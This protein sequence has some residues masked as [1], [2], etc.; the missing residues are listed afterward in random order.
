MDKIC[1]FIYATT[2]T[3][4]TNDI[5][6]TMSFL[7]PP[8]YNKMQLSVEEIMHFYPIKD[9]HTFLLNSE[10]PSASELALGIYPFYFVHNRQF[11]ATKLNCIHYEF[12]CN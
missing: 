9:W 4:D 11:S 2:I 1:V 5:R 3:K 10:D 8:E 12:T 6:I 7:M